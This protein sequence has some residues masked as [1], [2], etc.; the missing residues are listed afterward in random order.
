MR[1]FIAIDIPNTIKEELEKIQKFI[2]NDIKAKF[3]E[4]ENIHLTL[5]FLG[6]IND[7]KVNFVIEELKKLKIKKFEA[8]LNGVGFFPNENFIRVFWIG[9]EPKEIIEKI[10]EDIDN[11]LKKYFKKDKNFESHITL[12]RIK[13]IKNKEDFIKKI[14]NLEIK[15]TKFLVEE[16]KL[17]KSIL[18]KD[19][20]IYNDI[21]IFKLV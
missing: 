15:K 11:A 14:K 1:C 8:Y 7:Y 9:L 12:A 16:I 18:T 5:K 4:K 6:E 2:I 3:V 20:P 21:Y 17:K 10:H 13:S 19:G